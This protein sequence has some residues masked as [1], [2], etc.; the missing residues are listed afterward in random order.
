M[1]ISN[2]FKKKQ[3]LSNISL[4][5]DDFNLKNS[6]EF[7]H[8]LLTNGILLENINREYGRLFFIIY[9]EM[10]LSQL[11]DITISRGKGDKF[12]D[13]Y[14]N[15][16]ISLVDRDSYIISQKTFYNYADQIV[17]SINK[18]LFYNKINIEDDNP[19]LRLC[20]VYL[21]YSI[22]KIHTYN[23]N[24]ITEIINALEN[25]VQQRN[26]FAKQINF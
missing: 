4:L 10:I 14:R 23:S 13:Y 8:I 6:N 11:F 24:I 9:N 19:A 20:K 12:S 15:H 7:E 26:F 25:H 22:P 1:R 16:I 2:I 21:E 5:V 17:D 3:S 18:A